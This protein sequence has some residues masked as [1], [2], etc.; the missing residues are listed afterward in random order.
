[1]FSQAHFFSS[2]SQLLAEAN[3]FLENWNDSEKLIFVQTSGS[4]GVPKTIALEK[5]NMALSA[6]KTLDYFQL[7]KGNKA[8]LCLSMQTI[9]GK[10]MLLRSLL[11]ELD[12][13]I[14]APTS[15]PLKNVESEIDF[16]ALVPLQLETCLEENPKK[17][18]LI[19]KI[20]VG[21]APLS[22]K[23][24]QRLK[25][26]KL[27]IYQTF[28]MTET[29]S[30]IAL[31]KTGFDATST[32]EALSGIRFLEKEGKLLIDYPAFFEAPLE[33]NDMVQLEDST[34][35][36]WLGRADFIINSGGVKLNPEQIESKIAHLIPCAFIV[37]S[38]PDERLGSIAVLLLE[39]E[40]ELFIPK[41]ELENC[42]GKFEV[43]KKLAFT[44]KFTRTESGKIMRSESTLKIEANGWKPLL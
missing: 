10:M 40:N 1:M 11:G 9:A 16:L 8:L 31:K 38:L 37:T 15:N 43:P 18:H 44:T 39:S 36:E 19:K 2:D 4:T 6:K 22:E 42:L 3:D 23:I 33:T 21:G 17:L 29:I 14:I 20:I 24:I 5:K 25:A 7:K 27:T 34:H 13:E 30:H 35:F 32:Y 28:G 12:L 26:E 41:I